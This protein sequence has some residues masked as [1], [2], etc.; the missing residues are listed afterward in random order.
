MKLPGE[1]FSDVIK[2]SLL[3]GGKL[4]DIAGTKTVTKQEWALVEEAIE[5]LRAADDEKRRKLPS[6]FQK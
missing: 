2:R 3:K 6:S 5:K 4:M 1:S